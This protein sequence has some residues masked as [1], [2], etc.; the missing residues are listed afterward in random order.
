MQET[1]FST[2]QDGHYVI[3][4]PMHR[5][6]KNDIHLT[7]IVAA[8]TDQHYSWHVLYLYA[9]GHAPHDW[10]MQKFEEHIAALPQGLILN[11][12][13]LTDLARNMQAIYDCTIIASFNNHGVNR[14]S[15]MNGALGTSAIL[16]EGLDRE[17]WR[18]VFQ[19]IANRTAFFKKI[20][21][22]FK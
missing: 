1:K 20:Q 15:A 2:T 16:I 22:F 14:P 3:E 7:D 12:H 10:T 17:S 11:F 21:D 13:E 18:I 9:L 6:N 19:D 8:L 4:F 5:R